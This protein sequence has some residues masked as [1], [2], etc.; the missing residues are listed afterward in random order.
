MKL[1]LS[2]LTK[3][4]LG[5]ILCA[6][7]IFLPAGTLFYPGGLIFLALLFIPIL[8]FG[9]VLFFFAPDLLQKRLD[10]KEEEADQKKVTAII[11]L[12]FLFGFVVA[13]LD[14]RFSWSS[15]PLFLRIAASVIFLLSYGLY[16]EV[17]RENA[18]LSRNIKVHE[19]QKVVSTGL[20]GLVRHPMYFSTVF[21][22]LM[23]PLILGSFYSFL[24]FL[25]YPFLIAF[26]IRNEE[27]V[28]SRSLPGYEEYKKKVKYRLIPFIY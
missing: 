4:I 7:L 27:E 10:S 22:F 20:Y 14:F 16:V 13:G 28:L 25:L 24:L 3:F 5:L 18:Y 2:A 11:G 19:G 12:M 1:F 21:L 23:I 6:L 26:R 17:M 8:I 9:A 15:V